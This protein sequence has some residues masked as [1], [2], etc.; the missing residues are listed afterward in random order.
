VLTLSYGYKRPQSGDRG[1]LW[2]PAMEANIERLN[3]H[4]HDGVDSSLLSAG[5]IVKGSVTVAA[6]SWT[7]LST[8]KYKQ[9]VTCPAGFNM[10]DHIPSVRLATGHIIHPT[11]EKVSN[12]TFDIYTLDN[13]LTLTVI[14]R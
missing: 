13:S 1:A 7:L 4:D 11:I 12:T 3:D 9:T 14:F 10:T 5:V 6:A 8:G 2:F